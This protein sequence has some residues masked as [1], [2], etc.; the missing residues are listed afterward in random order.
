MLNIIPIRVLV[1][2]QGKLQTWY[3]KCCNNLSHSCVEDYPLSVIE[4]PCLDVLHLEI[5]LVPTTS[6]TFKDHDD[7]PYV[8]YDEVVSLIP[9]ILRRI[10]A[11]KLS[12]LRL[13]FSARDIN[14]KAPDEFL[15][16]LTASMGYSL[17]EM[18]L[19]SWFPNLK[20]IMLDLGGW[21]GDIPSWQSTIPKCFP[22]LAKVISIQVI[23]HNDV[24]YVVIAFDR[25]FCSPRLPV[26]RT[27]APTSTLSSTMDCKASG[28]TV[29]IMVQEKVHVEGQ[30]HLSTCTYGARRVLTSRLRL[31]VGCR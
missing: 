11:V 7:N 12:I 9:R 16:C 8:P 15:E 19:G 25:G 18:V 1:L 27:S 4:F 22:K 21:T 28:W 29:S 30:V 23:R 26:A 10:N 14:P 31:H 20:A 6:T 24:R 13:S 3:F 2:F 17:E 5:F